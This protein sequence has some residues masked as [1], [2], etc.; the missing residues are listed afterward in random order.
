M[1]RWPWLSSPGPRGLS[2]RRLPGQ[3]HHGTP[4]PGNSQMGFLPPSSGCSEEQGP[5]LGLG[6]VTQLAEL[7]DEFAAAGGSAGRPPDPLAQALETPPPQPS[8]EGGSILAGVGPGRVFVYL[9]ISSREFGRK[10]SISRPWRGARP[11]Q[12]QSP[13]AR[14]SLCSQGRAHS[15]ACCPSALALEA[16]SFGVWPVL[17][18]TSGW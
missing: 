6:G 10:T 4:V 11:H 17:P 2:H 1:P 3:P 15:G 5:R 14:P 18:R 12:C 8:P 13:V 16:S 7:L 9:L